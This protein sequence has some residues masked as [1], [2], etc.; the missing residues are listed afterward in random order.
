MNVTLHLRASVSPD[1]PSIKPR[2]RF[3]TGHV[4]RVCNLTTNETKKIDI[5]SI[6]N[7]SLPEEQT[8]KST[9]CVCVEWIISAAHQLA[10]W[11]S[12]PCQQTQLV[13]CASCHLLSTCLA[14][15][16]AADASPTFCVHR[17]AILVSDRIC[18]VS[19]GFTVLFAL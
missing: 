8:L 6:C 16:A 1:P 13:C 19:V 17:S 15:M 7:R 9:T 2:N 18:E 14:D 4:P 12:G 11:V 3:R 10:Y 5:Y